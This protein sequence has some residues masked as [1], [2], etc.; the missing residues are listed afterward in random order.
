MQTASVIQYVGI[1]YVIIMLLY[2]IREEHYVLL[3]LMLRNLY[4]VIHLS[5]LQCVYVAVKQQPTK[6][7]NGYYIQMMRNN[8]SCLY[9]TCASP[10]KN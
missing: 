7:S 1:C 10:C 5:L 6:H 9:Y 2:N 8:V 3:K 4:Y